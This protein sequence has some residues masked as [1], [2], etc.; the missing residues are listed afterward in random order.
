MTLGFSLRCDVGLVVRFW[1]LEL[2]PWRFSGADDDDVGTEPEEVGIH[3]D[4]LSKLNA[5]AAAAK[6]P[7]LEEE[8]DND[9]YP[10]N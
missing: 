6:K 1:P 4:L 10:G 3:T 2:I 5:A 9:P 7:T 8:Q